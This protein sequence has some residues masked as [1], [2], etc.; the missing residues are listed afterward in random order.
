[1]NV[2]QYTFQ[3]PYPSQVQVGRPDPSSTQESNSSDNG[4]E[5]IKSTNTSLSD[6]KN[7]QT[8]QKQEVKPTVN[9]GNVL[10]TYA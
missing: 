1:M 10:D 5:L 4:S 7:F 9:S 3:S 8:T 2:T 6:A